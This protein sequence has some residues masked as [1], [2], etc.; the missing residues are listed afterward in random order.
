MAGET[1][2]PVAAGHDA[3]AVEKE[4]V[5]IGDE[6]QRSRYS[7]DIPVIGRKPAQVERLGSSP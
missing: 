3:V 1:V 5:A 7:P 2:D 6:S 4:D